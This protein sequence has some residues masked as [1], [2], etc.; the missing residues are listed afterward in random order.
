[1][2]NVKALLLAAGLGTRLSP[3]TDNW[4]K[5]LMPIGERPLLEYWL[6]TLYLTNVSGVL[7]NLHH[8]SEIVQEFLNRSR[9]EGWVS[10]V[11][12]ESLL[13][14]A[15]TLRA[16]K[17]YFKNCTTL[18]VHADNWCQ[19]D[20]DGFVNYHHNHR[21][22][23]CSITMMTF[24][25]PTPETCGIV[26]TNQEG[27][28]TAFHEKTTP[29]PG[30]RANGAVYLLEPKVLKW[31]NKHPDV[32]DFST[33]VLPHFLGKI[34]TWNND[35]IHRDIGAFSILK[36]AQSDPQ[37][38]SC[39]PKIDSWQKDFLSNPIHQQIKQAVV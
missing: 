24:E 30:N 6:E 20:F 10:S 12:E 38:K 21:P 33:E 1:V 17:Y 35:G 2:I 14:T 18:L 25:S 3:L 26:E 36:Q 7:V 4:P 32:S 5:C 22:E 27:V 11:S 15:G 34:A 29:P 16:N 23:N 13:G 28:V 31:I 39:W 9:F 37:P 19:C 8:H